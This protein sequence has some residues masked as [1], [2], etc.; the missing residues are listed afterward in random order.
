MTMTLEKHL[1]RLQ[2]A[3]LGGIAQLFTDDDNNAIFLDHEL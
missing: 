2:V 3:I 1:D